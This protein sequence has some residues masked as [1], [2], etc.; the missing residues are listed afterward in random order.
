MLAAS[1]LEDTAKQSHP[2]KLRK[3]AL[4]Y[5]IGGTLRKNPSRAFSL[6]KRAA[7]LGDKN[8]A[9]Y[10]GMAL[11]EGFGVTQNLDESFA[12]LRTATSR[13]QKE[14]Y[15]ELGL[16][17]ENGWG[18]KPDFQEAQ[19]LYEKAASLGE[20]KALK[21]L[22]QSFVEH[23][24]NFKEAAKWI[25]L[26]SENKVPEAMVAQARSLLVSS[27]ENWPEALKILESCCEEQNDIAMAELAVF[28]REAKFC[29]ADFVASFVYAY[30][31]SSHGNYVCEEWLDKWREQLSEEDVQTAAQIVSLP[32]RKQILEALS[33][34][35]QQIIEKARLEDRTLSMKE[36]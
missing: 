29:P 26:A 35:G 6:F 36:Y 28:W 2:V 4:L 16:A 15:F 20:K 12:W 32:S 11:R 34:R 21:K 13:K 22:V 25:K 5:A 3:L 30:L 7:T 9:F 33:S 31:A 18:C 27:P 19:L 14:A 8:A 24:K 1:D 10:V 17:F 23:P